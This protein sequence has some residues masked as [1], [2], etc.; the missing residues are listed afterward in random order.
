MGSI[1]DEMTQVITII[2]LFFTIIQTHGQAYEFRHFHL[3]AS[4][5]RFGQSSRSTTIQTPSILESLRPF[6][7][8]N[9][10]ELGE[11]QVRDLIENHNLGGGVYNF[12]GFSWYRPMLNYQI[13]VDRKVVPD[14]V[15]SQWI[16]QDSFVISIEAA[17]LLTYLKEHNKIDITPKNLEAFAGL[18]FRRTYQYY[19]FADSY[20]KGL[21][22]D[23]RKLFLSFLSFDKNFLA[24]LEE[25][26]ILKKEDVFTFNAGGKIELPLGKGFDLQAGIVVNKA[27]TNKIVLQKTTD[28]EDFLRLSMEKEI[29]K[30][31]QSDLSLQYDFFHLLNLTLLSGELSYRFEKSKKTYLTFKR[32]DL[33]HM[34]PEQDYEL[35]RQLKGSHLVHYWK[36]RLTSFEDR[37]KQNLTSRYTFLLFGHLKKRASEQIIIVKEGIKKLFYRH[38]ATTKKTLQG[39]FSRIFSRFAQKFFTFDWN[40]R[41]KAYIKSDI[42]I[43]FEQENHHEYPVASHTSKLSTKITKAGYVEATHKWYHSRLKKLMLKNLIAWA[44]NSHNVI[45]HIERG[46]LI[47]PIEYASHLELTQ[48]SFHYLLGLNTHERNLIHTKFCERF[49]TERTKKNTC[50]HNLNKRLKKIKSAT[51]IPIQYLK[52]YLEYVL[53]FAKSFD[54][55]HALFGPENI[56]IHGQITAKQK[57]TNKRFTHF[58]KAGQFRGLGVIDTFKHNDIY[59]TIYHE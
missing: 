48:N 41:D 21:T 29:A 55:I 46:Q 45:D 37:M 49:S 11:Q 54:D 6:F 34:T 18:T 7:E 5:Q 9:Y 42:V 59:T 4:P 24:Q 3:K 12:N 28:Q 58:F 25:Q 35:S 26:E 33:T 51:N 50:L 52:Q 19:H 15:T 1:K 8:E 16:V 27:F 44:P 56:F 20:L 14:L 36:H 17:S 32:H 22:A 13:K 10:A 2:L 38:Y 57:Q 43:E 53:K 31:V 40:I 23:Y 47:G 30:R 39:L